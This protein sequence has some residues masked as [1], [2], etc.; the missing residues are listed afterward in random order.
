MSRPVH[1]EILADDPERLAGFYRDAFGWEIQTWSGPQSYWLVTTGA[2][3]TPGI[4]GGFMERH[5]DQ[6][7]INTI[8]VESLEE[9]LARVEAGGGTRVEGPHEIP[10]VGMHAYCK[11]PAGILFGVLQP[12]GQPGGAS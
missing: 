2:T 3:D 12:V 9:T 11:D 5:F 1:F 6:P 10:G 8:T 4:D 7:V